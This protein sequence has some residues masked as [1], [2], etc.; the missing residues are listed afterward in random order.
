MR[1]CAIVGLVLTLIGTVL[2]VVALVQD[3][4]EHGGGKP[5]IP[6]A[7]RLWRWLR[8]TPR[9][10]SVSAD[11]TASWNVAA[12]T[13]EV[14]VSPPSDAGVDV[15]MR[16]VRERLIALEARIAKE[17]R[18]V[19]RRIND[20]ETAGREADA[21]SQT[22]LAE[23]NDKIREVATGS[24]RLELWGLGLVGVGSIVSTLPAVFGWQ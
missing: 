20:V 8:R 17:R 11:T 7:A 4:N 16:F 1:I 21:R 3:W 23:V 15:Q 5:L 12:A 2:A 10:H 24:V 9:V 18:E 6:V 22:A 14:Y 19:D 13:G